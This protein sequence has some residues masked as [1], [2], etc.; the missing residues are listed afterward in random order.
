MLVPHGLV[1]LR[2]IRRSCSPFLCVVADAR[3]RGRRLSMYRT[4]T[5]TSSHLGA[6]HRFGDLRRDADAA[7]RS[8]RAR[9]GTFPP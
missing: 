1:M 2:S 7:P 6:A 9:Q 5:G 4:V 8:L 3:S